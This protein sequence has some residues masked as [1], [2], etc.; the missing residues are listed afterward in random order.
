MDGCAAHGVLYVWAALS[1]VRMPAG[2]QV[3]APAAALRRERLLRARARAHH[4]EA[5]LPQALMSASPLPCRRLI[6]TLCCRGM[7]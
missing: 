2:A 6:S 5:N 7:C 3:C 4:L 1:D